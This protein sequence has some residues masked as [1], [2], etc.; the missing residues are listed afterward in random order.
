M[1]KIK[2]KRKKHFKNKPMEV[3]LGDCSGYQTGRTVAES[4]R[5]KAGIPGLV[6]PGAGRKVSSKF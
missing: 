5:E 4:K 1:L 3:G 6:A 2:K